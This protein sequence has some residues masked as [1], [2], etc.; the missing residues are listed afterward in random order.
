MTSPAMAMLKTN[1]YQYWRIPLERQEVRSYPFCKKKNSSPSWSTLVA[2]R[3]PTQISIRVL[4]K[5][6]QAVE[7]QAHL[8][9]IAQP[10]RGHGREQ[11]LVLPRLFALHHLPLPPR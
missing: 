9:V 6:Y 2:D 3:W 8:R 11:T 4:R 5:A 10:R 1:M 7:P